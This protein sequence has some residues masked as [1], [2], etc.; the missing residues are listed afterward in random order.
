LPGTLRHKQ[1]TDMGLPR[2][3][4]VPATSVLDRE[5]YTVKKD[6][7]IGDKKYSAGTNMYLTQ[8][9]LNNIIKSFG[10]DVIGP[11]ESPVTNKDY[12]DKYG[13][14]EAEFNALTQQQQQFMQGLP[15]IT[16]KDYFDKFNMT[17]NDFLALPVLT[18]QRL[19]GIEPEYEFIEVET[20]TGVDVLRID[21]NNPEVPPV[22]IYSAEIAGDPDFFKITM[23]SVDDPGV[24]VS[25]I[26][27]ISTEE[28]REVI[29]KV[30]QINQETPGAAAMQRIGTESTRMSAFLVLGD[31]LGGGAS[32]RMSYDGGKTY[33]GSDGRPRLTPSNAFALS[34]TIAYD[35]YRREKVRS[36]ARQW[37]NE[38]DNTLNDG[39]YF[40]A[41]EGGA[42]IPE[43]TKEDKALVTDV[44]QQIRNGTGPWSAIGAGVNA[45]VGGVIAPE[46]FSAMFKETEEGRQF[47]KLVYVLGRSALASNPR[48]AVADLEVTGT[49]FPNPD[50]FFGNPVTEANKIVSLMKTLDAEESRLQQ[51][52]ASESPVDS[53]QL[54]IAEQKL[55][56][57]S[58]L[59]NLLGPVLRMRDTASPLDIS[60]AQNLMRRRLEEQ[61]QGAK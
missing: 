3:G 4:E 47:A 58:R 23:P 2:T 13:M 19:L 24:Q 30:N 52:R 51:L 61:L 39:Q 15:V 7:T 53:A 46:T 37:L 12:F 34:D 20:D 31:T 16:D 38:N 40:G 48:L 45:V 55:G 8:I 29:A 36:D 54:A 17:K 33:I 5:S 18:R 25:S 41:V 49:L 42:P 50:D 22:S 27:D 14:T 35:V 9:E 11:Y 57:I 10:N 60:G 59:K 32:V 44:L 43:I 26:V 28:G 21:K 56:E 1:L 6:M